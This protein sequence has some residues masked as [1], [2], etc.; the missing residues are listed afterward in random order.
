M[1]TIG[2]FSKIGNVTTKTLRYY[3]EI[4]LIRPAYVDQENRYRYYAQEQVYEILFVTELKS[5]GLR[6][7]QIKAILE[8]KDKELL[9]YFLRDRIE[10]IN[11]QMQENLRLKQNIEKKIERIQ[12]GGNIMDKTLD[13]VVEVKEFEPVL[14]VSKKAITDMSNISSVIGSVFETIFTAGLKAAG[15][16]IT[17]YFDEEFH[18][19][20]A[21]IEVCI[22]VEDSEKARNFEQVKLFKPGLCASCTYRGPY[23]RLGEAYAVV[24][25][26]IDESNYKIA[27]APFDCYISGPQETN[28]PENYI[29]KVYF[30]IKQ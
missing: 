5:Y 14:V 13:L 6:L 12:L 3:D 1:Y 9:Q 15:P 24:L 23:S 7:E 21:N 10:E 17:L 11:N 29:T 30:P 4:G 2:E 20:S 8:T 26:W 16:V 28:N 19:E 27:S 25:K 18:Q 22:P